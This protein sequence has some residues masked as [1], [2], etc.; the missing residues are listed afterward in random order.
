MS[1][2]V[3]RD[4]LQFERSA[5]APR[6]N[7]PSPIEGWNTRDSLSSMSPLEAITLDNWFPQ[8]GSVRSRGGISEAA[9]GFSGSVETVTS[10]N[11]GS[12]TTRIAASGDKIYTWTVGGAGVQIG[13]GFSSARWQDVNFNGNLLMVSD[14][15]L[16]TPQRFTVATGL[17]SLTIVLKDGG[18][19]PIV[20]TDADDMNGINVFKNHVYLWST[21]EGRFFVGL[22]NAIQGDFTEF[23]LSAV[24]DSGGSLIA[25]G[26]ITRDGGA[27]ADDL[28]AFIMSTGDVFIYNG[29]DPTSANDWVLE[30][31]YKIPAPISVRGVQRFKGDLKIITEVDQVSLL[32]VISSGGLNIRPS[33]LSGAFKDAV[34]LYGNNYGWEVELFSGS[35][36]LLFNIPVATNITYHQYV[37]NTVTGAACR[38]KGWNART[39]AVIDNDLFF[40][41]SGR[42]MQADT[43]TNDDSSPINIVSER[44]FTDFGSPSPKSFLGLKEVIR[45]SAT[46]N[47]TLGQSIDFGVASAPSPQTSTA[48]GTQWD[49]SQWD[50]FQWADDAT[51]QIINLALFGTGVAI[52]TKMSLSLLGDRAEWFRTDYNFR[53]N[54][55]F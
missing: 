8:T 15:S 30:G 14:S 26:T 29:D 55:T 39:F 42:I 43:G 25:M 16:D 17:T 27:G 37:I 40:G 45:S 4:R 36:M 48:S 21:D 44:A 38:F 47:L 35:D 49:T 22:L 24:S 1:I 41:E 9:T 51:A 20:G 6:Q 11:A 34:E 53:I 7:I 23:D 33:K 50:T 31:V 46:L 54:K 32:E 12:T 5:Q 10:L 18:G 52:S 28:A 19:T 2:P 3:R 13:S